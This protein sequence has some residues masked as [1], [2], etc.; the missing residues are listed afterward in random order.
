MFFK[1]HYAHHAFGMFKPGAECPK[2][3]EEYLETQE[4]FVDKFLTK[5]KPKAEGDDLEADKK[6][7]DVKSKATKKK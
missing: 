6:T 2:E 1:N 7:T 5:T 3:V 4:G